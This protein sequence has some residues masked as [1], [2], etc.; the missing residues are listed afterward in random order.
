VVSPAPTPILFAEVP[1]GVSGFQR[2]GYFVLLV[3]LFLIYSRIF[4]VK[5]FLHI[6][7]ISY[8]I[9]LAMV[10]LSH[11]FLTALKGSIGR[12]MGFMTLW[13]ILAIPTSLWRRGSIEILTD[14]WLPCFVI[15]LATAGLIGNF[16][17]CR[18]SIHIVGW[19]SS[20]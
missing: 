1:G 18:R 16:E 15:F 13:F 12:C 2:L 7:G 11:A 17:Q 9:I 10:F 20:F 19:L 3:Y 6:P 14:A 4:D 8:R 5:P